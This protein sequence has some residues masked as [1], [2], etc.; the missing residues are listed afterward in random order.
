[1]LLVMLLALNKAIYSQTFVWLSPLG[2][3]QSGRYRQVA[4]YSP[5]VKYMS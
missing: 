5:V 2:K 1:M 4:V 3:G